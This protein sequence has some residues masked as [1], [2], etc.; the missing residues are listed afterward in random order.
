M[1][2]NADIEKCSET[3]FHL[4]R[5]PEHTAAGKGNTLQGTK[6]LEAVGAAI[7]MIN[8]K[9]VVHY[10]I[11]QNIPSHQKAKEHVG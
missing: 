2:M 9:N 3:L 10:S 11:L 5:I 7:F 8:K 6:L 1:N 4:S